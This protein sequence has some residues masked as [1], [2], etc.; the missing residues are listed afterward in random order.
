MQTKSNIQLILEESER[1]IS[2]YTILSNLIEKYNINDNIFS[3]KKNMVYEVS[4]GYF[5]PIKEGDLKDLVYEMQSN[6]GIRI[7]KD[8]F[9]LGNLYENISQVEDINN[10]IEIKAI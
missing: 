1:K 8:K 7:I 2:I 4:S 3:F 9:Y 6:Q 10:M 5:T